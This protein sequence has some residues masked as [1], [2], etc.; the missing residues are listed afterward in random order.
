MLVHRRVLPR[1]G[2][3]IGTEK[4]LAPEEEQ[5]ETD[6]NKQENPK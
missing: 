6:E 2:I 3:K 4:D 5:T 1:F